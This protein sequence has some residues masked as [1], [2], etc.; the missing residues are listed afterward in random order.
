MQKSLVSSSSMHPIVAMQKIVS[1]SFGYIHCFLIRF[2]SFLIK[3]GFLM[4][5]PWDAIH[6]DFPEI[7]LKSPSG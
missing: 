4:S 3:K 2:F 6:L 5:I 1:S 7:Q